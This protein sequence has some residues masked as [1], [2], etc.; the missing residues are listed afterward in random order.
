VI[1]LAVA[2][3]CYLAILLL[4]M[5]ISVYPPRTPIFMSPGAQGALQE[6]V[7]FS[8]EDR[9]VLRGWW[10]EAERPKGV[11]VLVHGY[12]MNRSE[13]S[14]LAV[15]LSR[16]GCSCLL[17]DLRAH[18]R[19]GTARCGLGWIERLDVLAA[20]A[21]AR[22]RHPR[23][24]VAL[25]GSSMGAAACA[26]ALER[27]PGLA[28]ALVLDSC[29]SRLPRTILGWWSFL[30]GT[31]L[32]IAMSP[33]VLV[34]ALFTGVN[35]FR[36]DVAKCLSKLELPEWLVLHGDQDIIA[37]PAEARR[38]IESSQGKA[39]VVWFEGCGHSEGRWV[40]PETYLRAVERYLTQQGVLSASP[41]ETA[42][43]TP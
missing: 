20:V 22:N 1:W 5:R 4:A 18:G 26:F 40:K 42:S 21:F 13:L 19:S 29:Y 17:F 9:V 2:G 36:V 8:A 37:P 31:P 6:D 43:R 25:I 12:L 15:R 27:Q 24:T 3:L 41:S 11:A 32:R 23:A 30:G 39:T 34:G 16:Q 14:P 35:P 38:N 28:D 7:E 10:I 33:S